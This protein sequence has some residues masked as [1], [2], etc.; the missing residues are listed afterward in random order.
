MTTKIETESEDDAI[1]I[2]RLAKKKGVPS[3]AVER[4][5]SFFSGTPQ[6]VVKDEKYADKVMEAAK[7]Y[8][9]L[10]EQE[11]SQ[12]DSENQQGAAQA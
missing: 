10:K 1:A 6:V 7:E 12:Q 2:E 5:T 4:K 9:Q 11:Q 3:D 8:K